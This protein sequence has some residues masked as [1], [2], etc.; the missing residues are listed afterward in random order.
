MDKEPKP[1]EPPSIWIAFPLSNGNKI[2]IELS[3]KISVA[4]H[5][6]L[7]SVLTLMKHA[8]VEPINANQTGTN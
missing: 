6:T 3:K 5:D 4:D 7:I 2:R 8:L 1:I